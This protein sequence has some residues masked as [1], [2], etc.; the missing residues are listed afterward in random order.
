MT[1]TT[2]KSP[3]YLRPIEAK[4]AVHIGLSAG[5]AAL[6]AACALAILF[7]STA[8]QDFV[9]EGQ[10]L[11]QGD[12]SVRISL[13]APRDAVACVSRG[14]VT[15]V[16]RGGEWLE[17]RITDVIASAPQGSVVAYA[18]PVL[19]SSGIDGAVTATVK[20]SQSLASLLL[21]IRWWPGTTR[22][23]CDRP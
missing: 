22:Y 20:V 3:E 1:R 9:L 17:A 21:P 19:S 11:R 23:T 7:G 10:A 15:R 8:T 6:F 14:S 16:D 13:N 2:N 5:L 4:S 12:G 18:T